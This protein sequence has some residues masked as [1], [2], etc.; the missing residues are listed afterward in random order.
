MHFVYIRIIEKLQIEFNRIE[1]SNIEEDTFY[2]NVI[3][4]VDGRDHSID[5]RPSDAV[6]LALNRKI[7]IQVNESLFRRELTKEEIS[8]YEGIVKT[9]KF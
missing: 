6:A 3:F 5:C 7:P 9:V 4:L 8:E 1:I 2:A